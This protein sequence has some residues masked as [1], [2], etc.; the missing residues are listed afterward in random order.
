MAKKSFTSDHQKQSF[1]SISHPLPRIA[2]AVENL[3][4]DEDDDICPVCESECTCRNKSIT[5]PT[6]TVHT[7]TTP[8]SLFTPSPSSITPAIQN[9]HTHPL[10]IKLTLPPHLKSRRLPPETGGNVASQ[11]PPRRRGR[12]S[13]AAAACSRCCITD[14]GF[15]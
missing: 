15:R 9:A 14:S 8:I 13:K 1:T 10:K 5:T 12:P 4:L 2:D 11:I 6:T 7:T 3:S